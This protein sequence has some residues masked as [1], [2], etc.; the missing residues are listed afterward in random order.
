MKSAWKLAGKLF[1]RKVPLKALSFKF[2]LIQNQ[3]QSIQV[4]LIQLHFRP[5]FD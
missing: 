4:Y 1:Q 3:R 5:Q 2:V